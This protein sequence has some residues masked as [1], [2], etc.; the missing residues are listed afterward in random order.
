MSKIISAEDFK[1]YMRLLNY[2]KKYKWFFGIGFVT[3]LLLSSIDGFIAYSIAPFVNH[4][5]AD[6]HNYY[7]LPVIVMLIFLLRSIFS[8]CSDYFI[9]MC[10]LNVIVDI[11]KEIFKKILHTSYATQNIYGKE[12]LKTTI[13]NNVNQI[14]NGVTNILFII[15]RDGSLLI[16]LFIVMLVLC[17]QMTFVCFAICP[18]IV[19]IVKYFAK[20]MRNFSRNQNDAVV[21]LSESIDQAVSR[22]KIV[23]IFQNSNMN[24]INLIV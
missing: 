21:A 19:M 14:N 18:L 11:R 17:W 20:R 1:V 9:K 16:T 8:F 7:M 5:L 12:R 15:I 22:Y 3:T 10:G 24:T 13:L 6:T 2:A 4:M 23:H